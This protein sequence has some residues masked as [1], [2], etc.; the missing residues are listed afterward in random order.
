MNFIKKAPK[1]FK[2]VYMSNTFDGGFHSDEITLK[3][4]YTSPE[5]VCG[6]Q[7]FS[8]VVCID[9]AY[10]QGGL[11]DRI[12]GIVSIYAYCKQHHIPFYIHSTFPFE[13]K[14]Y[15]VPNQYDWYIAPEAVSHNP[16][17]AEP[18]LL[19]CHLLNYKFHR[20]YLNLRVKK[21]MKN[22]KQ[23]HI[24]TN[25][26]IEDDHF[27]ANFNELFKCAPKLQNLI[28]ET[29]KTLGNNYFSV[30]FRFQNLLGDFQ[31]DNNYELPDHEKQEL[32]EKCIRKIAE[33]HDSQFPNS[34]VLIAG[35]SKKFINAAQQ[36]LPYS[37]TIPG[38]VVHVDYA[39][40]VSYYDYAKVFIDWFLLSHA[41]KLYLLKTGKMYK[42]G[43]AKRA[44]KIS[45]A[46]Y[47]EVFF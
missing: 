36:A 4:R 17:E 14:D 28:E 39:L 26:F 24:Y 33:I 31:D 40:D 9:G 41:Q 8:I 10:R 13:L 37:L 20:H 35:D 27:T 46:P 5:K 19:F 43:F 3:K 6:D 25:T 34:Q 2:D 42:G 30:S 32:I 47:E 23:L 12:R 21:A 45:N 1:F 44:S 7:P 22:K 11:S 18:I 15:L 29:G 38:K 16:E